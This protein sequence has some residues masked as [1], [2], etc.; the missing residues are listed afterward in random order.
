MTDIDI[1]KQLQAIEAALK[2]RVGPTITGGQLF[3]L[4]SSAAPDLDIRAVVEIPKGPGALTEFVRRHLAGL[5]ERIGNHGGDI[6]YQI[7]GRDL[8]DLPPDSS[9]DIWRTFVSPSSSKHIVFSRSA[10]RLISRD[11]PASPADDEMEIS[12]ASAAEHDEIRANFTA[13]LSEGD[14]AA[15]NKHVAPDA[16]FASWIGTLREH[17]PEVTAKWGQYRRYRLS[18]LLATRIRELGLEEPLQQALLAQVKRVEVSAYEHS[19]R[20]DSANSNHGV[21]QGQADA[22][23][24][25]TQARRL[26]HAAID[27]LTYDELRSIKLPLGV[28]LDAFRAEH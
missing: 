20:N 25:T 4:I 7:D 28:M 8:G 16:K 10:G 6:L 27:L 23:H 3:S 24:V 13:S 2:E 19:K 22:P 18:D 26:A 9:I 21:K 5:V 12:K 11:T 17:L 1:S 15:L 14:A